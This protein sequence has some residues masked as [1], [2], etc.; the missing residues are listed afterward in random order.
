MLPLEKDH[1][2]SS[3]T[4]REL[5]GGMTKDR[6]FVSKTVGFE[7]LRLEVGVLP[8]LIINFDR[9]MPPL[10]DSCCWTT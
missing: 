2:E 5:G 7:G 6:G 9:V 4:G 1:I 3:F 10:L 8:G